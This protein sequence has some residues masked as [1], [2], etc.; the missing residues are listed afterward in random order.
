MYNKRSKYRDIYTKLFRNDKPYS[1]CH[2]NKRIK[3]E[4]M[5]CDATRSGMCVTNVCRKRYL[6]FMQ[7][8]LH[9]NSFF[10]QWL[11]D[12]IFKR[13]IEILSCCT[14]FLD[15]LDIIRTKVHRLLEWCIHFSLVL[16]IFVSI[17]SQICND[18]KSN[19]MCV[20]KSVG[21]QLVFR[22]FKTFEL[23]SFQ[24]P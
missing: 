6:Y 20:F 21:Y 9:K 24:T 8:N 22:S 19:E 2:I 18:N 14:M 5:L 15:I 13:F 11:Q 1:K 16:F 12:S 17:Y 3:S 10:I 4:R 7:I 23:I